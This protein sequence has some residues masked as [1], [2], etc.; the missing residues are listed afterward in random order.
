MKDEGTVESEAQ[1]NEITDRTDLD[2]M[3]HFWK[4][5]QP[6]ETKSGLVDALTAIIEELEQARLFPMISKHNK[7]NF[8]SVIRTCISLS[9]QKTSGDYMN[10]KQVLGE[11][12]DYWIEEPYELIVEIGIWK[13][14]RDFIHL[15]VAQNLATWKEIVY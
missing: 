1:Y 15:L 7:S 9:G 11:T 13:L 8:A 3:D 6:L 10:Q 5:V 2:F 14:Q 12:F 4:L